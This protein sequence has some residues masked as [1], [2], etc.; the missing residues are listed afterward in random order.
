MLKT[1]LFS[2]VAALLFLCGCSHDRN[3]NDQLNKSIRA[4]D[5]QLA[6]QILTQIRQRQFDAIIKQSVPQLQ[7]DKAAPLLGIIADYMN[8]GKLQQQDLVGW[9]VNKMLNLS[10]LYYQQDLGSTF[11]LLK[12]V[13][14]N[15]DKTPKLLNFDCQKL[16]HRLQDTNAFTFKGKIPSHYIMLTLTALTPL[17]ILLTFIRCMRQPIK[18]KWLWLTFILV[19][20]ITIS[21]NWTSG[22]IEITLL[23]A[24]ILG[25]S[26]FRGNMFSPWIITFSLPIGAALYWPFERII[27]KPTASPD[28]KEKSAATP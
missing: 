13:I 22:A 26:I 4:A 18:A 3:F 1:A 15:G 5:R 21:M 14:T 8:A 28:T 17:L 12:I 27:T 19:G 24:Q 7:N 9:H 6:E 20:L 25:A 2:F 16:S 10:T 11:L 23:H